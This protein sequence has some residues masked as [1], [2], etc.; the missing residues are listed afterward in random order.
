[1]LYSSVPKVG[2]IHPSLEGFPKGSGPGYLGKPSHQAQRGFKQVRSTLK[3]HQG[4][5]LLPG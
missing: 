3:T 1:M 5:L 4:G 2:A